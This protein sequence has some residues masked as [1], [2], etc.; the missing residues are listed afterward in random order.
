MVWIQ[1]NKVALKLRNGIVHLVKSE[2]LSVII[3]NAGTTCNIPSKEK[4]SVRSSAITD[5]LTYSNKIL[6]RDYC[7]ILDV[8]LDYRLQ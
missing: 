1:T 7:L 2:E 6:Q 5:V 8:N 4:F 3:K